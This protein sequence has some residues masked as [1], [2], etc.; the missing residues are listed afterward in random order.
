MAPLDTRAFDQQI[1]DLASTLGD[2]TR[3]GIYI[4][5]REAPE[6]VT[7]SQIAVLFEIHAN[8]ARHHLDRLVV[9]GYLQVT[10][11]RR[12][13]RRGPGAGRPER[14]F[15]MEMSGTVRRASPGGTSLSISRR[16]RFTR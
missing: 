5:V 16:V 1:G 11:K 4:S 3:R 7:A 8:V 12:S 14:K 6:P 15:N 10:H 13:G 2:A 9:D